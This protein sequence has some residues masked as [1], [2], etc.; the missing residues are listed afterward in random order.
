MLNSGATDHMTQI[1][2]L[3]ISYHS[4]VGNNRVQTTDDTLLHVGGIR[5]VIIE[6]VEQLEHVLFCTQLFISLLSFQEV[7]S[8]LPY[9][10]KFDGISFS[11]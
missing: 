7:A 9:K 11:P 3:F 6:P 8:L 4:C 2:S 5:A 1:S 10:I